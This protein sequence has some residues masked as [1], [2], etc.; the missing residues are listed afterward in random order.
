MRRAWPWLQALLLA[1]PL[2]AFSAWLARGAL[3]RSHGPGAAAPTAASTVTPRAL[4]AGFPAPEADLPQ[5][6]LEDR[7]DGAAEALRADGCRRLLYWRLASPAA[8]LELLVFRTAEG[9]HR[10]LDREVGPERTAGPGDEAQASAQAVYFRRGTVLVRLLLDPAAT[11][12]A[13]ALAARA[14]AVER[15]LAQ[16]AGL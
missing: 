2:V 6:R 7:V 9:A 1:A 15:G 4:L 16:G 13:D 11:A 3:A 10:S 8:D 5:G 14:V 12:G